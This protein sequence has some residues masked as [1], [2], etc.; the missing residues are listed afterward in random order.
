M[1]FN[2]YTFLIFFAVVLGMYHLPLPWRVKKFN[3]LW[4]SW[5]FYAAW[6]PPFVILL[7]ISTLLDWTCAKLIYNSPTK[8]RRNVMLV[9]S[10]CANLGFLGFFKYG[11]FLL[12]NFVAL[13]N[14]VGLDYHPAAPSIILPM[15]I[16][17]YTFVTLSYTLD[18]Y[19]GT[20]PPAKSFLDYAFYVAFFPHLVAGPIIRA[21]DFLP[22]CLTPKRATA[23]QMG[24]GLSMMTL[25][26]F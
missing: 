6:N 5:L 21:V 25:G 22:Q 13:A 26:L 16:S 10:L 1:L 11:N 9:L 18:V 14:A 3:L 20:M 8:R 12:Q 17:F 19:F 7:W 15:G 2:S 4:Q 24:F 23:A